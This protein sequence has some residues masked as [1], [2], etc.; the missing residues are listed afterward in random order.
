VRVNLV[1]AMALTRAMLPLLGA[2]ADAS[3]VLTLDTRGQAPRA[4]WGGYAVAKAGLFAMGTILA[5]EWE[6]RANL[7]VNAVVPGPIHSP[8]RGQT[9]PGEDRARLPNP[10]SL[11]PLYL[12]LL[13][14]QPKPKAASS[15]MRKR[16][17]RVKRHRHRCCQ[18]PARAPGCNA[19]QHAVA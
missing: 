11:V 3:V 1:A 16:G 17:L 19:I 15:S 13:G 7:R 18:Q 12:Y 9:H 14:A 5:D 10:T 2:A 4:Y 8:L 6:K